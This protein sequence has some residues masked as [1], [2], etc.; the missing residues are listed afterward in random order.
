MSDLTEIEN[1]FICSLTFGHETRRLNGNEQTLCTRRTNV[2]M[3]VDKMFA[4]FSGSCVRNVNN[5]KISCRTLVKLLLQF[6][7]KVTVLSRADVKPNV[8]QLRRKRLK[9]RK[10]FPP[11]PQLDSPIRQLGSTKCPIFGYSYI[12]D[13]T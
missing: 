5:I 8:S 3:K 9:R 7:M 13:G 2:C 6:A 10:T 1:R 4:C 11:F 12:N